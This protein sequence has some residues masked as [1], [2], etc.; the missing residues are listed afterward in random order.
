MRFSTAALIVVTLQNS[1]LL[2]SNDAFSPSSTAASLSSRIFHTS[3]TSL[4]LRK[5]DSHRVSAV[6]QDDNHDDNLQCD[7]KNNNDKKKSSSAVR[8]QSVLLGGA[9][10]QLSTAKVCR[11]HS[12][13]YITHVPPPP[14]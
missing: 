3:S 13:H 2:P 10:L 4:T 12:S 6:R 5:G 14:H 8:I 9:A 7:N 1:A 11:S